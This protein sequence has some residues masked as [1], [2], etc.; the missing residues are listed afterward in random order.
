M[1]IT[2]SMIHPQM[3]FLGKILRTVLPYYKKSTFDKCNFAMRFLKGHAGRGLR[4]QQIF[5]KRKDPKAAKLRLCIYRPKEEKQEVPGV[6]WIHGGGYAIGAPEQDE[7]FIREFMKQSGCTVVAPDYCLSDAKPYPTALD[8]CYRALLWMK[9]NAKALGIRDDQLMIG[10][11]SAGGG[12]TA[13]LAIYARD[14]GKVSIA[15][16]MPLYP[17]LDDRM[18]TISSQN[19]DAPVWNTKS[20]ELAWKQYLGDLYQ[21]DQVPVYAAPARLTNFHDLPPAVSYIGSIEP[22]KDETIEYMEK[23]KAAG[24]PAEYRI[25]S[26]CFHGFDTIAFY[27]EPAKEARKFLME[28]FMYAVEHYTKEQPKESTNDKC[29]NLK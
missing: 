18:K 6:L 2:D 9:K 23:L 3:R 20:N 24:I 16:Q 7:G 25:Y 14:R 1:H 13:G 28:Q 10:G 11:D 12:L 21:T 22:F 15:F 4:Y 27:S 26:G 8:D 19:N 5:I 29:Y 17:M